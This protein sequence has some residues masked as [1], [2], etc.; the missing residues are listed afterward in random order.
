MIDKCFW[1]LRQIGKGL[2]IGFALAMTAHWFQAT[3]I[4]DIL[5]LFG[6]GLALAVISLILFGLE[7]YMERIEKER[8]NG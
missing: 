1:W 2:V 3:P 4:F 7:K 8:R 6:G 5:V